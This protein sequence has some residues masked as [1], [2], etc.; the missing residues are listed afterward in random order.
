MGGDY[1]KEKRRLKRLEAQGG[2]ANEVTRTPSHINPSTEQNRDPNITTKDNNISSSGQSNS[3][4]ALLR[5]KRKLERKATGKFK[6]GNT[7]KKPQ[8]E[9]KQEKGKAA[10]R[11][12]SLPSKRPKTNTPKQDYSSNRKSP[13]TNVN[14]KLPPSKKKATKDKSEAN[15]KPKHLK[16]K[17]DQLSKSLTNGSPTASASGTDIT[18]LEA[19]MKEL[20]E[21]IEHFKRIKSTT[22]K[23]SKDSSET[24]TGGD[25]DIPQAQGENQNK[26]DGNDS[27]SSSE[28]SDDSS[29]APDENV[30]TDPA[31]ES[32][33]LLATSSSSSSEDDS[34]SEDEE[35]VNDSS[36][37]SRGK[38]RRGRRTEG[39]S[40]E[41]VNADEAIPL[42]AKSEVSEDKQV[43]VS[44]RSTD[45]VETASKKKTPKKEDTRRCIG[46]KPVT[47]YVVGQ[48]YSG[49]VKYI[50]SSLGA[51]IDIGS[52]S[53]AFCHISCISDEY[54]R[55]VDDVLKVNDS[56]EARVVEINREKKRITVSLR[57]EEMAQKEQD[58]LKAKKT[59]QS[60]KKK[61]GV[62]LNHTRFDKN[63]AEK[64]DNEEKENEVQT[65]TNSKSISSE[66][67]TQSKD[68]SSGGQKCGADL[69][70]ERK[71]A[72]RA[73]RRAQK[74]AE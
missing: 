14:K 1:A 11:I 53:D 55:S 43:Q 4:S 66:S 24:D 71:L 16:R 6:T 34:S 49:T 37:R 33:T 61:S 69:K 65:K 39:S 5:L 50:K 20:A 68:V 74:S 60:G 13:P 30:S 28:S 42:E 17:V 38:R 44:K 15:K 31:K 63:N 27:S 59:V 52:H 21:Q 67:G 12:Q 47:D 45:D 26:S 57:S 19:Q 73:E 9:S 3:S 40:K 23:A 58:D 8:L 35:V 51:F 10:E 70:R 72:R 36:A 56:V 54:A 62:M 29:S 41:K 32:K 25:K 46:R 18:Q 2:T 7:S 48:K 64:E 22:S